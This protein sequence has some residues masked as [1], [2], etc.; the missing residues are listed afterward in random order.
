MA[1]DGSATRERI[2]VAAVAIIDEVGEAAL[3][4][5]DVA[6]RAGITLSLITHYFGTRDHL[7]AEAHRRRF[8]GL[9]SADA[10][11]LVDLI[12]N[13]STREEL[14]A[15]LDAVTA[16][17][18]DRRRATVRLA[19]IATIG[20]A[21]GRPELLVELGAT[22]ADLNDRVARAVVAGQESGFVRPDVDARAV[23]TFISAYALGA[24]VADLDTR[25]AERSEIARV[26]G[27]FT[28]A[29]LAD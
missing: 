4:L 18:L 23:A 21:H 13:A 22:T 19:R 8:E 2:L 9:T 3:R 24:V 6:S 26:I 10:E 25:P 16:D 28:E 15:A 5:M 11:Q 29:M 17:V 20:A 27:L 1:N 7:V 14:L 12:R